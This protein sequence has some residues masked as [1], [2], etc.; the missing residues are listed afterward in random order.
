[1][2]V[3]DDEDDEARERDGDAADE[4]DE[5]PAR[6]V[7]HDRGEHRKDERARPWWDG[8]ELGVD[9]AIAERLDD[10]GREVR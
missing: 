9:R 8:E 6:P 5:A 2:V 1:M 7:G 3:H 4:E 10:C